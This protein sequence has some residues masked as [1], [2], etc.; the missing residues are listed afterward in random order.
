M[1]I[2]LTLF[3]ITLSLASPTQTFAK[4]QAM[5]SREPREDGR[6]RSCAAREKTLTTR[7]ARLTNLATNMMTKFDGH[8]E[9]IEKHYTTKILPK[10]AELSN[11]ESLLANIKDKKAAVQVALAESQANT[12]AFKCESDDPKAQLQQFR[13]NMQTVKQ[14]LHQYRT[15]IKDLIVAINSIK[16]ISTP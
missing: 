4:N 8:V 3:L 10:G 9:R 7:M 11:Y 16:V 2:L 1:K 13:S 6:I 12:D 14:A 15:S 5:N